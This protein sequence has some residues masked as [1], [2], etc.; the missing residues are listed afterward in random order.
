MFIV[1]LAF[2]TLLDVASLSDGT[3][4]TTQGD[5]A[6]WFLIRQITFKSNTTNGITT[7]QSYDRLNRSTAM[8]RMNIRTSIGAIF[9]CFLGF[10]LLKESRI[11]AEEPGIQ[12]GNTAPAGQRDRPEARLADLPAPDASLAAAA[13]QVKYRVGHRGAMAEAPENTLAAIRRAIEAGATAVEM[14]VRTSR[15]GW[16]FLLHDATLDRTTSGRGRARDL[17]LAELQALDASGRFAL[18]Y[19]GERI[20]ALRESLALCRG[21]AGVLLDLK[22]AGEAYARAVADEVRRFGEPARTILGVHSVAD[23]ALFRGLLPEARQ[24]GLIEK[25]D[26]IE[27][28]A[29]AGVDMIRLWPKWIGDGTTVE[30][31]RRS[32]AQLHLNATRGSIDEMR[33]LLPHG[34]ISLLADDPARLRDSLDRIRA[35]AEGG[36]GAAVGDPPAESESSSAETLPRGYVRGDVISYSYVPIRVYTPK[37]GIGILP[38]LMEYYLMKWSGD[39]P[40]AAY[41]AENI[42]RIDIA[43]QW[44]TAIMLYARKDEWRDELIDLMIRAFHHR[45][46]LVIRCYYDSRKPADEQYIPFRHILEKLW[47]NRDRELVNPEGQRA[48]G[49]QIINN[50]LASKLGDEGEC[51]LRTAGLERVYGDYDRTIR[52]RR[53]NG[54]QPFRHI[55]GW[56]NMLGYA[57]LNYD[58]CYAAT[59]ED[60]DQRQRVR[61]PSNVQAIGVDVYHYWFHKHSPFDPADRSIPRAAV[62]AHSDEWQRI[63]TRYY[64]EGLRVGVCTNS[65]DP[66]TWIPACW[67]DTHALMSGIEL[68]GA[69]GA[70]M[71]YIAACGQLGP[72]KGDESTYTTPV[73]TMESY[74]DHLKAG[75]WVALA[76]WV[77][78]SDRTCHG[79]LEYYD[80]TLEHYTPQHPEGEPYSPEMLNYWHDAYVGAKKRMF[81]DVVYGQFRHLN[82]KGRP[83]ALLSR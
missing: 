65:H 25:P 78:G 61:L 14:D 26:D 50:M 4:G 63:R 19:R 37:E 28:F 67:N 80:K 33:V 70:E 64:P 36:S 72:S 46:L 58:G 29:A 13:A 2:D 81:N 1:D 16:L 35:G 6:D 39:Q 38:Y 73:E 55:K 79:G 34:P 40:L 75:P 76:W 20:P 24:L 15:D 23:A 52:L 68:A 83:D 45:Q 42:R 69:Q 62:R 17:T 27:S 9:L 43:S 74:Y 21:K 11:N 12:S 41:H 59:Q 7:A 54:E 47:E 31:V 82:A 48:T 66:R 56:Y 44:S 8:R 3:C 30:R 32:G 60:V 22:E 51:G 57:A 53:L 10:A 49:R 5:L 77:F 71:W 18:S